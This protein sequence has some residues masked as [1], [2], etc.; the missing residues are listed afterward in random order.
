MISSY[1]KT[2]YENDINYHAEI[3]RL[4]L[5]EGWIFYHVFGL[6]LID[7]IK[8]GKDKFIKFEFTDGVVVMVSTR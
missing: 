7:Q 3:E 1:N 5:E 4:I 6:F 8:Q 2:R